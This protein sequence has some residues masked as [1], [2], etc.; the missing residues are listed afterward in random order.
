M[1]DMAEQ[2]VESLTKAI[3]A[4]DGWGFMHEGTD[5]FKFDF[6]EKTS[7]GFIVHVRGPHDEESK[8]TFSLVEARHKGETRARY[9][10]PEDQTHICDT[11]IG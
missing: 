2:F 3:E 1:E 10:G 7:E 11:G 6:V 9:F 5:G 4:N 8:L